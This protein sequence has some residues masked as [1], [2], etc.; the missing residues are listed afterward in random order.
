MRRR[1][2][3]ARDGVARIHG[4]VVSRRGRRP[5][6]RPSN[7][8]HLH[9]SPLFG[10]LMPHLETLAS[11]MT[12][13]I[14]KPTL[15]ALFYRLAILHF[16]SRIIPTIGADAWE[17]E[18]GVDGGWDGRPVG[19]HR[20]KRLDLLILPRSRHISRTSSSPTGK[21]YSRRFTLTCCVR[22]VHLCRRLVL[23]TP[24]AQSSIIHNRSGGGG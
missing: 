23:I 16:A 7:A 9:S 12:T 17:G 10:N 18:T 13:A 1:Y 3:P 2:G 22:T 11:F 4:I 19:C 8:N 20:P 14:P 21:Q 6:T 5:R 15:F 24:G